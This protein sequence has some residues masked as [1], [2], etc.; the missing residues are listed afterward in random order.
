MPAHIPR[1]HKLSVSEDTER[2]HHRIAELEAMLLPQL[3]VAQNE[4]KTQLEAVAAQLQELEQRYAETCEK[5][6]QQEKEGNILRRRLDT[7]T[8]TNT[9]HKCFSKWS[10]LL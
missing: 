3:Q 5:I 6:A 7:A 8:R 9:L 2:L 4:D 1:P 10:M